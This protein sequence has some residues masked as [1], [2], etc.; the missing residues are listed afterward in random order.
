[1]DAPHNHAAQLEQSVHALVHQMASD[2]LL[3]AA[4]FSELLMLQDESNPSFVTE[5]V[6]LYFQV[7]AQRQRRRRA[8][9]GPPCARC[10]GAGPFHAAGQ[11]EIIITPLLLLLLC[12]TLAAR[13]SAWARC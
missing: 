12:R 11:V 13:L 2:G 4:Q 5:V 8:T 6:L 1:M 7:R 10:V 9:A 3:D